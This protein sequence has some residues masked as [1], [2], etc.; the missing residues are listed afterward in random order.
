MDRTRL[1]WLVLAA[2]LAM[3]AA[4]AL[5]PPPGAFQGDEPYY[6][7]KAQQLTEHGR[8]D[9]A[10]PEELAVERGERWGTADWRPPGYPF[11]L[12]LAGGG[13]LDP[14]T[15]RPR[16][17]AIQFIAI[18]A[19]LLTIFALFGRGAPLTVAIILGVAPWPFEFV[20]SLYPDA[21]TAAL[22]FFGAVVLWR[23]ILSRRAVTMFAGAL[24]SAAA[25]LLRPE[26]IVVA[27][28]VTAAALLFVRFDM[29][30]TVAAA[31]A[32]LLVCGLQYAYRI[33]LTGERIPTFFSGFH[34][35]SLGAVHW[36]N[37]RMLSEHQGLD[38]VVYAMAEGREP[39][40]PPRAVADAREA[41]E[42]ERAV[43][44]LR[45]DRRNSAA[46]D[47]VFETLARER[48]RKAP[49]RGWLLPRITHIG[50]L[51]INLNTNRQTLAKLVVVPRLVRGA[52]LL[53]LFAL[54]C[55]AVAL[56]CAAVVMLVRDR[57][58]W[59]EH[60]MLVALFATLVIARTLL[61]AVVINMM[62]HRYVTAV[63]PALLACAAISAQ[64]RAH[65]QPRG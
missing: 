21:L 57:H 16:V 14:A 17:A 18:A 22:T 51:W 10:T 60:W 55:A 52:L 13:R 28:V 23:A 9:R 63:W 56:F 26:T 43:A 32:F 5:P 61:I 36:V 41:E 65:L 38:D 64:R 40:I 30:L 15:L 62:E 6:V 45:R 3:Q 42:I 8:F 7:D 48:V 47:G 46:V 59:G 39:R 19:V 20:T 44:M 4:I 34:T 2:L 11:V 53:A 1:S 37:T 31:A 27:A 25:F 58:V 35:Q 54:K 50:Q 24:L 12:A 49:I 29:R 33:Q